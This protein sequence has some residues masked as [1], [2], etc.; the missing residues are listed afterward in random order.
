MRSRAATG[1][2]RTGMRACYSVLTADRAAIALAA[3]IAKVLQIF[4]QDA[5][6]LQL[7]ALKLAW[8]QSRHVGRSGLD[9]VDA[10]GGDVERLAELVDRH[11]VE[12]LAETLLDHAGAAR[13][14]ESDQG[15]ARWAPQLRHRRLRCA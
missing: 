11:C 6:H 15:F 10:I 1:S 2:T 4:L 14:D 13:I 12:G 7:R 5:Q 3:Q 9:R 8:E